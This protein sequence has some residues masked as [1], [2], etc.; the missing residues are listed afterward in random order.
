MCVCETGTEFFTLATDGGSSSL[1][2]LTLLKL[3]M[4][5]V[6]EAINS[7]MLFFAGGVSFLLLHLVVFPLAGE[8]FVVNICFF[9]LF[10]EF[11]NFS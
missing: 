11:P 5:F 3:F 10:T 2:A 8:Y 6:N 4:Q 9:K 1:A 7:N